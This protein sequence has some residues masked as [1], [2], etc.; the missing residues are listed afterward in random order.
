[1]PPTYFKASWA[2]FVPGQNI[3]SSVLPQFWWCHTLL[4][5]NILPNTSA[6]YSVGDKCARCVP[7]LHWFKPSFQWNI[8]S[9]TIFKALSHLFLQ[10]LL[11]FFQHHLTQHSLH[12]LG[13]QNGRHHGN[14]SCHFLAEYSAADVTLYDVS[15]SGSL[16]VGQS[17]ILHMHHGIL[18][19]NISSA[20]RPRH[21]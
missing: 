5:Q 12:Q 8:A 21:S 11:Q 9:A 17:G 20:N 3:L 7:V 16:Y 10:F 4:Q 13:W 14:P 2:L 18:F 6:E 19:Q 15:S 1:M